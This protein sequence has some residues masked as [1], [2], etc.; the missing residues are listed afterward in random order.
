MPLLPRD[1]E[2]F[3]LQPGMHCTKRM[4]LIFSLEEEAERLANEYRVLLD[5]LCDA[6]VKSEDEDEICECVNSQVDAL[7][8]LRESQ[9]LCYAQIEDL[10]PRCG[11]D[12]LLM[13]TEKRPKGC[14]EV[15]CAHCGRK[16]SIDARCCVTCGDAIEMGDTW[17]YCSDCKI[18]YC[19]PVGYCAAC[20]KDLTV[21]VRR[22][23]V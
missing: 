13:T 18:A 11:S 16:N 10:K 22:K 17:R 6:V 3:E 15:V 19:A 1:Y 9:R 7:L 12:G 21:E 14:N 5:A 8:D 20:G 4:S 2:K 23:G